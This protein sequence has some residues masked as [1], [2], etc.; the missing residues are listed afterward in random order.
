[1]TGVRGTGAPQLCVVIAAYNAQATLSAQLAALA[2]QEASFP[3][4]VLICD[5]GST[6][7]TAALARHWQQRLPA[8]RV[9]DASARRGPAAARNTGVAHTTAP[10]IAFCDADDVVAPGWLTGMHT[11]LHHHP[12][13]TGSIEGDRLNA[14]NR[15]SWD[16]TTDS[17]FEHQLLPQL[18]AAGSGNMGIH[19]AVFE[20]VGGF[21]EAMATNE[22][23]DLSWRVQLA[24]YPLVHRPEIVLHVR[25][26]DGLRAVFR[27]AYAYG[28]GDRELE[29][30]YQRVIAAYAASPGGQPAAP[31]Q[32]APGE[33][34][35]PPWT[36]AGQVLGK[37]LR[38]RGRRDLVDR[39]RRVG[40]ALG[41]RFAGRYGDLAQIDPPARL[42]RPNRS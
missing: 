17:F 5:N 14:G 20:E 40:Y 36:R 24:G 38:V 31:S 13:V 8:L 18:P 29:H 22:D 21:E 2:D 6:D 37:L 3:W 16:W 1:M 39:T 42:P 32:A 30:R 23:T 28:K 9:I 34:P 10:Y 7:D 15:A 25:K 4:E 12:F 41:H 27:Q 33:H 11:A 26:R 19:R 35:T